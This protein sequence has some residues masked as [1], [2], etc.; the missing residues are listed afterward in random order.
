LDCELSIIGGEKIEMS[1]ANFRVPKRS[2]GTLLIIIGLIFAAAGL[3]ML[4]NSVIFKLRASVATGVISKLV[5]KSGSKGVVY[6][7]VFQFRDS[8][9]QEHAVV[10]NNASSRRIA[11]IGD[12]ITIL[13]ERDNPE[14]ARIDNAFFQYEFPSIFLCIGT[15]L[16]VAGSLMLRSSEQVIEESGGFAE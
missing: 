7:P 12:H 5:I 3:G 2:I 11:H 6:A 4:V 1:R 8:T 9:G 10:S 13:Y 14:N 16:T 15:V